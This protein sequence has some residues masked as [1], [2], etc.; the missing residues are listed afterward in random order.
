[1]NKAKI[2]KASEQ[3]NAKHQESCQ[4]RTILESNG[5]AIR[6]RQFPRTS[7]TRQPRSGASARTWHLSANSQCKWLNFQREIDTQ[8]MNMVVAALTTGIDATV[9][10]AQQ[11]A[12]Q[13]FQPQAQPQQFQATFKAEQSLQNETDLHRGE[14]DGQRHCRQR[15]N[16]MKSILIKI[17]WTN[18]FIEKNTQPAEAVGATKCS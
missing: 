17:C 8:N 2:E 3:Y 18:N 5:M 15:S 4:S 11:T 7:R 9:S 12:Q 10:Q 6:K 14:Q 13:Q 16:E 1:M